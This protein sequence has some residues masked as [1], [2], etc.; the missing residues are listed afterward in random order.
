LS[1][2]FR[3]RSRHGCQ[4]TYDIEKKLMTGILA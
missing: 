2:N 4:H 1:K 3:D